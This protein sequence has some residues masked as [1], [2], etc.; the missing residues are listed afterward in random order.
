MKKHFRYYLAAWVILVAAFNAIV[1]CLPSEINGYQKILGATV[2]G[3]AMIMLSFAG[4]LIC[5]WIALHRGGAQRLFLRLPLLTIS[6]T[7]LI[8]SILAGTACMA[9]PNLPNWFGAV[10][11]VA[12]LAFTAVAVI[13]ASAAAEIVEETGADIERRTSFIR[14]M[15]AK[16]ESLTAKARTDAARAA[17]RQVY[18]AFRYSDPVSAVALTDEEQR[19]AEAFDAFSAAIAAGEDG[20]EPAETLS[21]L[22]T[23]RNAK[24]KA[25]K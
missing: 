22:L 6:Y 19:I 7:A 2:S 1:F 8:V 18:E 25:M 10:V 12:I 17:C 14:A 23:E 11:C 5:A 15:T 24:C 4:Q 9:I 3:Y 16:A 20:T 13:K 21:G